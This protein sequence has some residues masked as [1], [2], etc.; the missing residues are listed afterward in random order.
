MP[1]VNQP[2]GQTVGYHIRSGDHEITLYDWERYVDFADRH[3]RRVG[4]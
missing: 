1:A 3:L 4:R 2:I